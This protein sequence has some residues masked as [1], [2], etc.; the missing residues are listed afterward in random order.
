[1]KK[2]KEEPCDNCN[3]DVCCCVIRKQET[4]EE[5]A[6]NYAENEIKDRGNNNDKLICSI[7]FIEG[8]KWQQEQDKNKYSE[9]DM[10]QFAFVC[11]ANF[12]SNNNNKVEMSLVE[13]ITDRN[14]KK[15]EQFKKK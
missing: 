6:K 7:D 1:M 15:F 10:K 11:V 12:L 13:V 3:N 9:E 8:A 5:A 4:L 2:A 14:N